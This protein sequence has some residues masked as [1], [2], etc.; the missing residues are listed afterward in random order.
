[1]ASWRVLACTK[2]LDTSY[3]VDVY[4]QLTSCCDDLL[5]I[6]EYVDVYGTPLVWQYANELSPVI[7]G[8][9]LQK[10]VWAFVDKES[11][12][13]ERFQNAMFTVAKKT[14]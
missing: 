9:R 1:M 2:A 7:T 4:F 10:F 6:A 12:H 8:G 3:V 5:Q 11:A 13:W 14:R